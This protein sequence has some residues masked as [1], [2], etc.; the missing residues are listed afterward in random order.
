MT[1]PADE[2]DL[3]ESRA[4]DE[5]LRLATRLLASARAGRDDIVEE[6]FRLVSPP[7]DTEFCLQAAALLESPGDAKWFLDRAIGLAPQDGN[8][9]TRAAEQLYFHDLVD[10]ATDL[11]EQAKS[12]EPFTL[13]ARRSYLAGAI[14]RD[15]GADERAEEAFAAAFH[16]DPKERDH[17]FDYALCLANRQRSREALSVVD[18][19]LRYSPGDESLLDLRRVLTFDLPAWGG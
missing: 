14:A 17:G 12:L 7:D 3:A 8:V 19:A 13:S 5:L 11:A 4:Q 10:E 15:E 1:Q 6:A 9:L 2:D 16:T 18:T